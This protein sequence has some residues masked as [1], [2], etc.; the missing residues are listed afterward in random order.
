MKYLKQITLIAFLWLLVINSGT[1]G[2]LDTELRLQMSHAWWTGKEEVQISPEMTRK[3]RGDIRFGVIGTN[4]KRYIAYEQG[5]SILMLPGDWLG[6]Q[7]ARVF[8]ILDE[9]DW[10]ELIVSF[11]IFIPIN[12][13]VVVASYWL[14]KLL[15][16]PDK[17]A[18]VSSLILLL[19]TTI[20]HHAQVHQQNNQILV[21]LIVGYAGVLSFIKTK[22]YQ[23]LFLSGLALGGTIL[24]RITCL[25]HVLTVGLFLLGC[26]L[27]NNR[28]NIQDNLKPLGIF[29]TGL[30]PLTLLGRILDFSRYGS[31]FVSGKSV[32]KAQLQTDPMWQGLP[33]LPPNY[34]LIN[35]PHVGILGP[36]ISP[37]K[38]LFIYDPLLLPGLV[39]G[40]TYWRR[41]SPYLQWYLITIGFNITLH[42]FAY[43]R[44]FFWHGD[45]AWAARYHVTS[46][47]LLLI[48]LIAVIVKELPRL[49]ALKK[50][51]IKAIIGLAILVQLAS[52][53]MPFNLE[54][55]QSQMGMAGSKYDLRIVQRVINIVCLINPSISKYC[56]PNYPEQEKFVKSFNHFNFF[57]H[58]L[59]EKIAN[60][61]IN[62]LILGFWL[63]AL[64]AAISLTFYFFKVKLP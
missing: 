1:L 54:I 27:Y 33:D 5:Q 48:P 35:S 23:V 55:Y 21:L 40:I 32:E 60:P 4:N 7:I 29:M 20:L 10:R 41:F 2:V 45:H 31:F 9:Q 42:L 19:G 13:A 14:L 49:K 15:E 18:A 47:H 12:I 36:L 58:I 8:P 11:F 3:I 39:V 34:P 37:A 62:R 63:I 38:S 52:V 57:P 64:I 25:L 43:S 17:V 16:F 6:T 26:L 28:K 61:W 59:S 53:A 50:N 24:I 44:F 56:I 30:I 22:N 51:L 46:I